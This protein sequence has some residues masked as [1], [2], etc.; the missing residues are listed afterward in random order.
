MHFIV[1]I[2]SSVYICATAG[3]NGMHIRVL[4]KWKRNRK[5]GCA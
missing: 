1:E 5:L 4:E 2:A 3:K